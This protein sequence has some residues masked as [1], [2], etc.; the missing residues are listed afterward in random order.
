MSKEDEHQPQPFAF[1]EHEQ[2]F[3]RISDARFRELVERT[4]TTLHE[5]SL[6]TNNYGEFLFVTVSW[7][8]GQGRE[9]VTFWGQG[10]H[11]YR[12]RWIADVWYWYRSERRDLEG[13]TI[14]R[15]Q[16]AEQLEER[17]AFVADYSDQDTQSQRG[18]L[19][20]FLADMTD[21][22]GAVI[23]LEEYESWLDSLDD[24]L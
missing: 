13:M 18:A 15:E 23:D 22:D 14:P 1:S 24:D 10:Y 7:Q 16:F 17:A 20:E 5:A 19:F 8:S 9:Q 4:D 6:S 21:E 2:L 12:E 3:D 11:E